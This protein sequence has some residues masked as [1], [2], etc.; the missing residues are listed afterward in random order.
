MGI[1]FLFFQ[2]F[3]YIIISPIIAIHASIL[4]GMLTYNYSNF[5]LP[6]LAP[7]SQHHRSMFLSTLCGGA[8]GVRCPVAFAEV[9]GGGGGK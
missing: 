7:L 6:D 5:L 9:S 2:K 4:Q 8:D 3:R 1:T